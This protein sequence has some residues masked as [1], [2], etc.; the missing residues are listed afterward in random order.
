MVLL[1]PPVIPAPHEEGCC[2]SL[3]IPGESLEDL[4]WALRQLRRRHARARNDTPLTYR[5]LALKSGY[6]RSTIGDYISGKALPP[7][8]RLDV[9]ALL[10]GASGDE[11]RAL[12]TARG[13][14]EERLRRRPGA[15][16]KSSSVAPE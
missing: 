11:R 2:M 13:P 3:S 10:L 9:L 4:A 14:I 5:E 15:P 8:D 6:S 12:G 7:T 16:G 1:A